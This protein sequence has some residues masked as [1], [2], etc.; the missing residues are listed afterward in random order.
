M[1]ESPAGLCPSGHILAATCVLLSPPHRS[2]HCL[3]DGTLLQALSEA[4][5]CPPPDGA[6]PR[7]RRYLWEDLDACA[8]VRKAS[9]L[10]VAAGP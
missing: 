5:V 9:V 7:G 10:E 3:L 1:L 8:G 4:S 2:P 6:W